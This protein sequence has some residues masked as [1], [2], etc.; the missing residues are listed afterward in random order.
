MLK[1]ILL[2]LLSLFPLF[3]LSANDEA[4]HVLN[5]ISVKHIS[6]LC[7]CKN[8]EYRKCLDVTVEKCKFELE[9]IAE[10]C[11]KKFTKKVPDLNVENFQE[12][13]ESVRKL[14]IDFGNCLIDEHVLSKG[15]QEINIS[16]CLN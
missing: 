3:V 16:N 14:G 15:R 2:I 6:Y 12:V 9:V 10:K 5:K 4:E 11:I 7:D 8:K 13:E 1:I